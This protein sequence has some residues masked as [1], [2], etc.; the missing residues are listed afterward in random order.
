M[1][2]F[3][4]EEILKNNSIARIISTG[5]DVIGFSSGQYHFPE[6]YLA[7]LES[8]GAEAAVENFALL[9]NEERSEIGRYIEEL[10]R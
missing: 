6:H 2:A 9:T 4:K 8:G 7:W 5:K 10:S 1:T 3:L